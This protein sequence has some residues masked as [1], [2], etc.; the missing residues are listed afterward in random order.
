MHA[1]IFW[2]FIVLLPTILIAMIGI[3]DR[4]ATFPWLGHQGWYALLVDIF[5]TLVLVGVIAAL[6]IR[7]VQRPR[8][9]AGSHLGEADLILGMIATIVISLL[10]W[11]ATRIALGINDWPASWTP[12][13]K[14]L[15]HLFSG[16]SGTKVLERVF[17][18]VHVLTILAFLA[19]LPGS[20][21]LHIFTAAPN[22]WFTRTERGGGL[23]P[24]VSSPRRVRARRTSA[25]APASPRISPGS[26]SST[27]SPARSVA[28]A[29]M[30][31]RRTRRAKSSRR[32]S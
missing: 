6:W 7:K 19:Y 14:A 4:T 26:R 17:V 25:S 2:G 12:V 8:R 32:N 29:R 27:R 18:W 15:S 13:A 11:H 20:K 28:A 3:V 16:G 5:A 10:L 23:S 24:C 22:V 9:F 1:F 30:S 31:A 21:H